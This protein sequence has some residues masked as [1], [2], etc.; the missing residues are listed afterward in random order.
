MLTMVN[1]I[2]T[3]NCAVDL[4]VQLRY[5]MARLVREIGNSVEDDL[6][7]RLRMFYGL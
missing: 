6:K 3:N 1:A 5:E 7:L 4:A 2:S